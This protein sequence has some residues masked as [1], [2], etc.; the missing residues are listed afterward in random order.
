M[1]GYHDGDFC[2]GDAGNLGGGAEYL[3]KS[4]DK[5]N[6]KEGR[7]IKDEY[8]IFFKTKK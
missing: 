2:F 8:L 4:A 6:D 7:I 1:A 5:T 3:C